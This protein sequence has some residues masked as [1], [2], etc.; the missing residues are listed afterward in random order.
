MF[1]VPT[2]RTWPQIIR[3]MFFVNACTRWS[4]AGLAFGA[5]IIR[6]HWGLWENLWKHNRWCVYYSFLFDHK[7]DTGFKI[8]H[9]SEYDHLKFLIW[10]STPVRCRQCDSAWLYMRAWV[11]EPQFTSMV[12]KTSLNIWLWYL[13]L[14]YINWYFNQFTSNSLMK[15]V[16]E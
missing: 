4:S 2:I 9:I 11:D 6:R 15:Y 8:Q 13:I 10:S 12:E 5:P 1:F 7:Q 14:A 3:P 16:K